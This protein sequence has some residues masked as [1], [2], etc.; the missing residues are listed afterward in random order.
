MNTK[1]KLGKEQG[2]NMKKYQNQWKKKFAA[3]LEKRYL[4]K[5]QLLLNF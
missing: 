5:N 4:L 2:M 1:H 3:N